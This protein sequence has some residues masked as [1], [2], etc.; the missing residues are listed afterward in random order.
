MS[1]RLLNKERDI[2][3]FLFQSTHPS[4]SEQNKLETITKGL[5]YIA[6]YVSF[7]CFAPGDQEE[8]CLVISL[9]TQHLT[10]CLAYGWA[11]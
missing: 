9:D 3:R 7:K 10:W 8:W 1:L 2:I 6:I 4:S 11:S 5:L